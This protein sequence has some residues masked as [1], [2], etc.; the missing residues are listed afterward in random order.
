M[1]YGVYALLI[2]N[3][4]VAVNI[5]LRSALVATPLDLSSIGLKFFFV[6]WSVV[7]FG[8]GYFSRKDYLIKE[9]NFVERFKAL[10]CEEMRSLF[11]KDFFSK[12]AK[13]FFY[14]FLGA[15][16]W[17]IIGYW[18][19]LSRR[20]IYVICIVFLVMAIILYVAQRILE[21]HIQEKIIQLEKFS[22]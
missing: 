18:T 13:M 2:W 5:I 20:V 16:P 6:L 15:I 7:M 8:V 14:I 1:K 9:Q 21:R 4:I 19:E 22:R 11:K 10:P 12:T 3:C 17:F